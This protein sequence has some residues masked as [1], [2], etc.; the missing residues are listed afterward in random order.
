MTVPIAVSDTRT[1]TGA[2]VIAIDW[3]DDTGTP[4]VALFPPDKWRSANRLIRR[5]IR[6]ENDQ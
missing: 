3:L 6:R 4:R 2:S 5:I 1:I